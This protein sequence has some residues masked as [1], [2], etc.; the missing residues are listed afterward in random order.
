MLGLGAQTTAGSTA[1][2]TRAP[3]GNATSSGSGATTDLK[4]AGG[5]ALPGGLY[6][7]GQRYYDASTG[8]W[9]EP[10]PIR[11]VADLEQANMFAYAGGDPINAIDLQG[12]KKAD[13]ILN[14]VSV[15]TGAVGL[16]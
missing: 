9:I 16:G 14:G 12:L 15:T 3:D 8:R 13:D 11:Q 5:Y 2:Y 7:F 4:F 6:H 1:A 10:D